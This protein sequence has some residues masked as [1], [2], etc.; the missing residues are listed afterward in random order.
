MI[1][2][3]R[4]YVHDNLDKKKRKNIK[5]PSILKKSEVAPMNMSTIAKNTMKT[6]NISGPKLHKSLGKKTVGLLGKGMTGLWL[7][8][9]IFN[10]MKKS[11][12]IPL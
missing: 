4:R 8:T 3:V 2:Y 5:C 11:K 6:P 12:N 7:G 9:S 1:S 10:V